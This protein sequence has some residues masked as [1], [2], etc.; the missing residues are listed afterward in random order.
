V[1][2]GEVVADGTTSGLNLTRQRRRSRR[3]PRSR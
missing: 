2:P 3:I 1:N